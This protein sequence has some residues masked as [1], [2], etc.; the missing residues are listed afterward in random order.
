MAEG[1]KK[2]SN[3]RRKLLEGHKK[4]VEGRKKSVECH[5]KLLENRRRA[6]GSVGSGP[7]RMKLWREDVVRKLSRRPWE[8]EEVREVV[9]RP[10]K[11]AGCSVV[12][13]GSRK[14]WQEQE[15]VGGQG[16]VVE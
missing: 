14:R 10:E 13:G 8:V 1:G 11:L 9:P 7:K 4:L 12:G 15:V 3:G 2:L 16:V 5:R 6:L